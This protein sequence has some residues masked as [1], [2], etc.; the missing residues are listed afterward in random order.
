MIFP[1]GDE[2][3]NGGS[4]PI[5]SYAFIGLNIL[6]FLFQVM[7]PLE[8]LNGFITNYG[9]IPTDILQF[10]NMHTLFSS[11]FLHG[12]WMHLIGNMV[13]LWVFA[14]NIEAI[15]GNINFL[16]FYILGGIAASFAHILFNSASVVPSIGA[17]GAIAA[18]LGAYIVMFP[19]SKVKVLILLFFTTIRIPAILFLGIWIIQQF[20]NGIGSLSVESSHIG[21]VAWWAHIG[22]FLFGVASGFLAKKAYMTN[23]KYLPVDYV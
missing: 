4:K 23:K 6:I 8:Q 9:A 15:I 3:V 5:F 14:D 21:G 22:G 10:E 18:V 1:I 2:Q 19:A 20:I 11:M 13:F 12:G 17:S 7:L 16:A